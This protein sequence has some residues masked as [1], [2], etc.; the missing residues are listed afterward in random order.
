MI[1]PVAVSTELPEIVAVF[2]IVPAG[3]LELTATMS[4]NVAVSPDASEGFVQFTMPLAPT[5]GVVQLQ[6][7]GAESEVNVVPIGR[8]SFIATSGATLGPDAATSIV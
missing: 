1:G 3:R 6:P 8:T 7:A 2:E 5:A 4:V